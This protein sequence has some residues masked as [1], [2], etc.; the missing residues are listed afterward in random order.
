MSKGLE[1]F[2]NILAEG[3]FRYF[4]SLYDID[5]FKEDII[6]VKKEL[7]ALKI[8]SKAY[9]DYANHK[10]SEYELIMIIGENTNN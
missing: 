5:M 7:E 2:N 10:I 9:G 3:D 4:S 1:A 8:I 6:A